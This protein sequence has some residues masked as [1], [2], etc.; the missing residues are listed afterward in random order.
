MWLGMLHRSRFLASLVDGWNEWGCKGTACLY[1]SWMGRN[2]FLFVSY[3]ASCV[4]LSA[5]GINL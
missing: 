4:A 1:F 5:V 2:S 3:M